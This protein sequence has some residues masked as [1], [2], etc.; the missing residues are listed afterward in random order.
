LVK[1]LHPIREIAARVSQIENGQV[2]LT[3]VAIEQNGKPH[4][5][6]NGFA[7]RISPLEATVAALAEPI[8]FPPL[9]AGIVPGDRVTIALDEAI[10]CAPEIVRGAIQSLQRAGV[11]SDS[12]SVVSCDSTT[13]HLCRDGCAVEESSGVKFVVHD[14]DDE[15]NLCWVGATKRGESIVINRT[16]FDADVVLPIGCARVDGRG[17]YE[18]LFPRFS[19]SEAIRRYRTPSQLESPTERASRVRETNEAGW[20]VGVPMVVEVVPGAGE[21]A[22]HVIAGE[23]NAVARESQRL[24][25]QQWTMESPQQVSLLIATLTGG[26]ESQTWANVGRALAAAEQLV[27]EGGAVAICSNLSEKPGHSLGRLIGNADVEAAERK[28]SHDHDSDSWAALQVARALQRGPV[29]LLSQLSDETVEDLGLAPVES[30]DD[31][32]RLAERHES[33]AVVEDSQNVVVTLLSAAD[34]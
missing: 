26:P 15:K 9:A 13:N 3:R 23:P 29:Y 33:F 12:I 32:I 34:E 5:G 27:A 24:S 6:D 7:S 18:S 10:P 28:I 20:L 21:S 31:L 14:P 19:N 17:A 30:V 25:E 22:A 16:I 4:A 8:E 11:E 1:P 2:H